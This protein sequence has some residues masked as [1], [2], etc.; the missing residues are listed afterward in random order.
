[1]EYALKDVS[2]FTKFYSFRSYVA[3]F[4]QHISNYKRKKKNHLTFHASY[5]VVAHKALSQMLSFHLYLLKEMLSTLFLVTVMTQIA[6]ISSEMS[7][8]AQ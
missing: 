3:T 2:V 7:V 5:H 4:T 8:S 6:T 1:M